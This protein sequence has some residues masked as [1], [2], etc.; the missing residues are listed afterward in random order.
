VLNHFL[1]VTPALFCGTG[2]YE[3][4]HYQIDFQTFS[5]KLGRFDEVR[6]INKK[7]SIF[8]VFLKT[9][10][11]S[12]KILKSFFLLFIFLLNFLFISEFNAI[13]FLNGV[14]IFIT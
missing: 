13:Y 11:R 7:L 9:P 5:L 10:Q 1:V 12:V 3:F 2:D 6:A 14:L 8:D 4:A